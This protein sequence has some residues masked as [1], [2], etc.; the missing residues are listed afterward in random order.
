MARLCRTFTLLLAAL[1]VSAT[2]AAQ[3]RRWELEVYGGAVAA[4]TA[5]EGTRTL[6]APGAPIVTSNPLFPS[7]EVPSWFFGDGAALV[8]AVNE[9][10]AGTSRIGALDSVFVA[11]EPRSTGIAGARLRRS[12]SARAAF[13]LAVDFLGNAHV[14]TADFAATI[15]SAR[16]SFTDTFT[17][18][19]GS[20]PFAGIV[21]EAAAD[22]TADTRREIAATASMNTDV[23]RL[24]PLTPY[25][26]VGGGIVTGV[27]ALPSAQL[28]GRYRFSVLGQVPIDETDRV[29]IHFDRPLTFAAVIGGGL[30]RTLSERWGM[31]FDVRAFVGPDS[32]RIRLTAEPSRQLG[33]PSG[34]IESFTNPAIQFSNDAAIGRQSSLSAAA[35]DRATIFDAGM[36]TRTMLSFAISRRF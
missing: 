10:F 15:E 13:E 12:I 31:R 14:A 16:H 11:T 30:R 36:H 5:S 35:I 20:G 22:V 34:F 7:R 1:S 6:P 29:A 25:V 24:G 33:S 27:G 26:T 21:V 17:E 4:R 9:E 32:T 2:A 28:S 8:N 3:D 19:L 18:L 23:G